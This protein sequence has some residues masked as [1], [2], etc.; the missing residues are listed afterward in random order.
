VVKRIG[1]Q[2]IPLLEARPSFK[3]FRATILEQG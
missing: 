2:L 1:Q 3:H